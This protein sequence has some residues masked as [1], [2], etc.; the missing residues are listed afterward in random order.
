MTEYLDARQVIDRIHGAIGDGSKN[1][2]DNTRKLI[3]ML[4]CAPRVPVIHVAGTNGK[5]STC[6]MT[7]SVLKEAGYRT[8]LYTSP[9]L[10]IY[11]ERIRINGTP[12]SDDVL[13]R[14]G[15]RVLQAAEELKK[16]GVFA[17]P[18][19]LGTALALRVF[20]AENVEYIVLEVGMGGRL[21]P[22][23]AVEHPSVCA[24]TAIGL[25]HMQ[26][27]GDTLTAIA[28]E[29]AGIIKEGVPVVCHTQPPE[30]EA[31]FRAAA[32]RKHA[33]LIMTDPSMILKEESRR[34]GTRADLKTAAE[35]KDLWIPLPGKHQVTNTLVVLGIIDELRAR[36]TD[37][38]DEA[39]YRGIASTVWPARA[40]WRGALLMDGAHN[41]QGVTS[42]ADYVQ[43]ELQ[44]T[45]RV[46]LTGVLKEKLSDE[47]LRKLACMART[48][49][50]VTPDSP[51]AM[52]A[53]ELAE[54]LKEYG[55]NVTAAGSI[56][57][58][59]QTARELAGE[60]GVVIATGS[61][62][63]VGQ[64]RGIVGLKP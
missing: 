14:E 36:G 3:G 43:R 8:G 21:D 32:E 24:I 1:G 50:T 42:L 2:L 58:G 18:F 53:S 49:V 13:A 40:E 47:M 56:A 62:Y 19:E 17:T 30:V 37:I 55:M 52:A 28:G 45:P 38:P 41:A 64:L 44:D 29:K 33:R 16:E 54:I 35:W 5:G 4:D 20:A 6:A 25:D 7:A 9:F 59:L 39:V 34:T 51:R 48:A 63:F 22:T 26:Y 23:N 46:L 61:L 57:E 12:V 11:N 10:Q 15:N 27:L 60:H 31:V